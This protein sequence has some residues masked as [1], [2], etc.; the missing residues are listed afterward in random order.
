[1]SQPVVIVLASGKGER[2][3]ASGGTAPKLKALLAGKPLLE[4]T[5]DAVK[6]SGLRWHVEQGAHPGM[7]DSIA[8]GVRAT[9]DASGWLILPG[10]LPLIQPQ[11]LVAVADALAH[12][13][14][15]V[16]HY[17]GQRGHPVGFGETCETALRSLS[18]MNGAQS[19]VRAEAA[20]DA[21][22]D[23]SIDDEGI[24]IDV[25]TVAD[26]RAAELRLAAR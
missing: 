7:G 6:A 26:L 1:M 8:A 20:V 24:V 16:P 4:W 14:V 3:A 22:H 25:D 9:R 19:I 21:V 12:Y 2:F 15:V 23:M 11:T 17:N 5:L 18:G 13:D 10:D